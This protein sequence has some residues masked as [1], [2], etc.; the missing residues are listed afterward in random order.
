MTITIIIIIIFII[1]Y[2]LLLLLQV[3]H[4]S[5]AEAADK[6]I[7]KTPHYGGMPNVAG[8]RHCPL[9]V[10]ANKYIWERSK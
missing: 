8:M 7:V 9:L 3:D 4:Q 2:L 10:E 1:C 6:N 5:C